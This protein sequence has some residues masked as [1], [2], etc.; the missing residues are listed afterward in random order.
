MFN[1]EVLRQ[2]LDERIK[3]LNLTGRDVLKFVHVPFTTPAKSFV[4]TLDN[5]AEE[6]TEVTQVDAEIEKD[7][8]E[9]EGFVLGENEVK[10]ELAKAEE[11]P[12][13]IFEPAPAPRKID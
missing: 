8:E 2:T 6:L 4:K 5:A 12:E 11:M 13:A 7:N 3:F 10:V 9:D 1:V